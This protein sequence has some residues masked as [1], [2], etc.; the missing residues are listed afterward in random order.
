M[1]SLIRVRKYDPRYQLHSTIWGLAV[2]ERSY[3]VEDCFDYIST[4]SYI[5]NRCTL[6]INGE[7]FPKSVR[8]YEQHNMD[9]R[10]NKVYSV[11]PIP[12]RRSGHTITVYR[13]VPICEIPSGHDIG[14]SIRRSNSRSR[15]QFLEE[16]AVH[17]VDT[18]PVVKTGKFRSARIG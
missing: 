6:G 17:L 13:T 8:L 5:T 18:P 15:Q 14:S 16:L 12:W 3:Y 10:F 4:G 9:S 7:G 2:E 11:E 1:N